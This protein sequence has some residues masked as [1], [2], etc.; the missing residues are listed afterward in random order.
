MRRREMAA[1]PVLVVKDQRSEEHNRY[2]QLV[3]SRRQFEDRFQAL[4][5]RT[6]DAAF[7]CPVREEGTELGATLAEALRP[8][9]GFTPQAETALDGWEQLIHPDD[10]AV[11]AAHLQRV[12]GGRRDL[13]VF[14]VVTAAGTVRWFGVLTR[15]VRDAS[16]RHLAHVYGLIQGYSTR[17]ETPAAPTTADAALLHMV[18]PSDF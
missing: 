4:A 15:S 8:L 13:C 9:I 10:H 6:F 1:M 3:A 5:R 14:R 16:G 11:V 18:A 12:L 7:E 17:L 2:Q